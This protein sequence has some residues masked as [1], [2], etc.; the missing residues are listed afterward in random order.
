MDSDVGEQAKRVD[1][2]KSS[3][4]LPEEIFGER[5]VPM[6]VQEGWALWGQ[7]VTAGRYTV[8]RSFDRQRIVCQPPDIQ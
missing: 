4:R 7:E 2:D 8:R 5:A 3:K 1:T 6:S